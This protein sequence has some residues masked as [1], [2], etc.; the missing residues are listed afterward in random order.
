MSRTDSKNCNDRVVTVLLRQI[1]ALSIFV[2][3]NQQH[4]GPK[5][6]RFWP[7]QAFFRHLKPEQLVELLIFLLTES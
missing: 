7:I 5:S 2:I 6:D 1:Q 4:E 3:F